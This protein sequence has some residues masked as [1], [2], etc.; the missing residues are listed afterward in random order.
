MIK[1][2]YT[3]LF[4]LV[5]FLLNLYGKF[6]GFVVHHNITVILRP[7]GTLWREFIK[8]HLQLEITLLPFYKM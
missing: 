4:L 2:N 6:C 7:T 3:P 5:A 1:Y 8:D